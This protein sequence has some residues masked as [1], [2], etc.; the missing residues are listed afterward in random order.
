MQ[1]AF[2]PWPKSEA[3]LAGS[4]GI[5]LP[6]GSTEQH[7]PSGLIGTDAMVPDAIAHAIGERCGALVA[8]PLAIRVSQ[9]NLPFPG[10]MSVAASTLQAPA[11]DWLRHLARH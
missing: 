10:T 5:L 4:R 7:R 8:P 3:Y 9:F 11:D 2:C 6:I 1:L